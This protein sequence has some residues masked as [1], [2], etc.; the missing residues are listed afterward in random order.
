[1]SSA[2]VAADRAR[3]AIIEPLANSFLLLSLSLILA[4]DVFT[5]ALTSLVCCCSSCKAHNNVGR[6]QWFG[7]RAHILNTS[8]KRAEVQL[9]GAMR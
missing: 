6:R 1:M 5:P 3:A 8:G 9:T 4:V 7:R 2:L